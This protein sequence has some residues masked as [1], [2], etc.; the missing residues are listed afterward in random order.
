MCDSLTTVLIP[1]WDG[2]DTTLRF[3][4]FQSFYFVFFVLFYLDL[5]P[6]HLAVG[7]VPTALKRYSPRNFRNV[8]SEE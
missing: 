1:N 2:Y 7:E 6:G 5:V 8:F 4:Y 3:P